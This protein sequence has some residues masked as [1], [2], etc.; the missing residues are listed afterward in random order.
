MNRTPAVRCDEDASRGPDTRAT[1]CCSCQSSS[2]RG[3]IAGENSAGSVGMRSSCGRELYHGAAQAVAKRKNWNSGETG[4]S[5][6]SILGPPRSHTHAPSH[7]DVTRLRRQAAPDPSA[8]AP[9]TVP[10]VC[11]RRPSG[12]QL[13]IVRELCTAHT[14]VAAWRVIAHAQKHVDSP[15]HS[16]EPIIVPSALPPVIDVDAQS[17]YAPAED[18]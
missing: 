17:K 1:G 12:Q 18:S 4:E 3:L 2:Y 5:G 6:A 7:S 9:S 13:S 10:L 15:W 14:A 11:A 8:D 16:A